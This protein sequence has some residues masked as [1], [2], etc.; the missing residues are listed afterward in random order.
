MDLELEWTLVGVECSAAAS[1]VSAL[2]GFDTVC[3]GACLKNDFA[4]EIEGT[5]AGNH[6]PF[7][8]ENEK[9]LES[10]FFGRHM[11]YLECYHILQGGNL[12]FQFHSAV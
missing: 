6:E 8:G 4:L 11:Y 2:V 7:F 1:I 9:D 3:P 12:H 10:V 5:H